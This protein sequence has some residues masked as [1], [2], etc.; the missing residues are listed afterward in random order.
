MQTISHTTLDSTF[1]DMNGPLAYWG[2]VRSN[3]TSRTPLASVSA[4]ERATLARLGG[5]LNG[6]T[7]SGTNELIRSLIA[8]PQ[9]ELALVG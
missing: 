3:G 1:G 7:W 2:P 9:R 6:R 5:A 4:E 8:T